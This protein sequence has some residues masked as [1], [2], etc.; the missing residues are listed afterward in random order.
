MTHIVRT[1]YL[2]AALVV[3][4][5]LFA[6]TP[7]IA[8][9]PADPPE[10]PCT[11]LKWGS[12]KWKKCRQQNGLPTGLS[13]AAEQ[14]LVLAYA[15]AKDGNYDETIATL[16]PFATVMDPRI[17]TTLGFAERKLGRVDTAMD[18]YNAAL[19][20]DPTNLATLEYMGEAHLQKGDL[21][22]ARA[23]LETIK[24]LC[25]AG[26]P[27]YVAL[28]AAIARYPATGGPDASKLERAS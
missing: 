25:G 18:F 8:M 14:A 7:S 17:L 27:A 5:A 12:A 24:G 2:M 23:H 26:C 20:L 4:S 10:K 6:A 19:A 3:A 28:E 13:E 22:K 11:Q 1:S 21:D 15:Q 9:A 16:K